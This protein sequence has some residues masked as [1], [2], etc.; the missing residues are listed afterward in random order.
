MQQTK[1]I[2]DSAQ[3]QTA[4]DNSDRETIVM[5]KGLQEGTRGQ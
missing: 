4:L 5:D 2:R 3:A 1:E